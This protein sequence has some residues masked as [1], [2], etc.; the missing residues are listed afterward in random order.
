MTDFNTIMQGFVAAQIA[1]NK[2]GDFSP[3][4]GVDY[5][6]GVN[7]AL[8]AKLSAPAELLPLPN[9]ALRGVMMPGMEAVRQSEGV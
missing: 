2:R 7:A 3:D 4:A 6:N 1:A 9:K 5:L 8:E